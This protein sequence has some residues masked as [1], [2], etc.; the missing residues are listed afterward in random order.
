[1]IWLG[2][3]DFYLWACEDIIWPDLALPFG[4]QEAIPLEFNKDF[5]RF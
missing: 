2:L 1:M 5:L 4:P 3:L